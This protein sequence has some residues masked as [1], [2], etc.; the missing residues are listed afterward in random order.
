MNA[1]TIKTGQFC[2]KSYR[3]GVYMLNYVSPRNAS[4]VRIYL[5]YLTVWYFHYICKRNNSIITTAILYITKCT[6]RQADRAYHYTYLAEPLFREYWNESGTSKSKQTRLLAVICLS[7]LITVDC[8]DFVYW[9]TCVCYVKK[10]TR[11]CLLSLPSCLSY[12]DGV[13]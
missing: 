9:N 13:G 10:Q 2:L 4:S 6:C 7:W 11:L 3:F 5:H 8:L 1:S 12:L